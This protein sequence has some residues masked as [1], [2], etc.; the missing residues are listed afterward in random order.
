MIIPDSIATIYKTY[1]DEFLTSDLTSYTC[2]LYYPPKR[3]ACTN[4]ATT[5][6]GGG[7]M[8]A[9]RH[10]GPAP[11]GIGSNCQICGGT[12]YRETEVTDEIRLR[13]YFSRKDWVRVA[14]IQVPD[15]EI[16]TIGYLTDIQKIAKCSY[17]EVINRESGNLRMRFEL[18]GEPFEHGFVKDRYFMAFWKKK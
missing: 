14:P 7:N 9:F 4:C 16:M 6:F 10:G 12:Q 8:N 2:T 13:V 15:A 11:V 5:G 18:A 17:I 3:E 1:A